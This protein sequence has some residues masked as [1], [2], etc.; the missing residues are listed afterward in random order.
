MVLDLCLTRIWDFGPDWDT[1]SWLLPLLKV[2][3]LELP[4]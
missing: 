1:G 2:L 3:E 4:L